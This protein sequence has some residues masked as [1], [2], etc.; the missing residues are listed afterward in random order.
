MEGGTPNIWPAKTKPDNLKK[1]VNES[2][3]KNIKRVR[4][5]SFS[6]AIDHTVL[7]MLTSHFNHSFHIVPVLLEKNYKVLLYLGPF[8][9]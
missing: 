2:L 4:S 7:L 5:F 8:F 1:P 6:A 9:F 3:K